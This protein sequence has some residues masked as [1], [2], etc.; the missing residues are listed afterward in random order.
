M[1]ERHRNWQKSKAQGS[2]S[3]DSHC[4]E[5][6]NERR[7]R[8]LHTKWLRFRFNKRVLK[9]R[10][11]YVN[12]LIHEK[13]VQF[14]KK[15]GQMKA[16]APFFVWWVGLFSSPSLRCIYSTTVSLYTLQ[17]N[18]LSAAASLKVTCVYTEVCS[19]VMR[20]LYVFNFDAWNFMSMFLCPRTHWKTRCCIT[21]GPTETQQR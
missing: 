5:W 21:R 13:K 2:D 6:K 14:L 19:D 17:L 20:D 9:P 4:R 16:D 11:A 8:L 15:T 3:D 7:K 10:C 18:S 12:L 1:I